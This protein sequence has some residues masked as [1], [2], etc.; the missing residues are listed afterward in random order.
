MVTNPEL[1]GVL[2]AVEKRHS[3]TINSQYTHV[4]HICTREFPEALELIFVWE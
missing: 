4:L 3:P 2:L 1:V